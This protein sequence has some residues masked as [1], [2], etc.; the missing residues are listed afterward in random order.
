[1]RITLF[2]FV[3]NLQ[4]KQKL[5]LQILMPRSLEDAIIN[6]I[7]LLEPY[8]EAICLEVNGP[9]S[10][11]YKY[12]EIIICN[13]RRRDCIFA[14]ILQ[15]KCLQCDV[16]TCMSCYYCSIPMGFI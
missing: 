3:C 6:Y 7:V 12:V 14:K 10:T 2:L 9:I 5:L 16:S 8:E 11:N 4:G 13:P 1:M 15:Q